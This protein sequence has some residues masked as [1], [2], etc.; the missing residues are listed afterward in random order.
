MGKGNIIVVVKIKDG[1]KNGYYIFDIICLLE[2]YR[3][4]ILVVKNGEI[5]LIIWY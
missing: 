1:G 3:K 4:N 2:E 5:D